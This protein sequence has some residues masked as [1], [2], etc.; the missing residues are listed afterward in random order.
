MTMTESIVEDE[1]A[2]GAVPRARGL[3]RGALRA[4]S[5]LLLL[6]AVIALLSGVLL[7]RLAGATA[8]TV[9]SGSMSPTYPPGTLVVV[10]PTDPDDIHVG[11]VVTF[12]TDSETKAVVT[13]RVVNTL[14]STD[15]TGQR[16]FVVQ[17]DANAMPDALA[18]RAEQ[19]R[20]TVWY[21]VPWLGRANLW[22]TG[23]LRQVLVDLGAVLL[24]C[25]GAV[26]VVSGVREQRRG[27]EANDA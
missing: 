27:R 11:D 6:A 14:I 21:A 24:L 18:V 5:A 26:S 17:G 19:L 8:Y 15:G 3:V 23:P 10:R 20:G 22:L 13:H 7:P 9:M 12:E 16:Q 4:G 1:A 2:A 25:F